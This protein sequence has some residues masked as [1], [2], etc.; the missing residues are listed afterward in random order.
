MNFSNILNISFTFV[1]PSCKCVTLHIITRYKL[2]RDFFK[3]KSIYLYFLIEHF[4]WD[5]V[6]F[7]QFFR[8]VLLQISFRIRNDVFRVP[9]QLNFGFDQIRIH[10]TDNI[11]IPQWVEKCGR[12]CNLMVNRKQDCFLYQTK[13]MFMDGWIFFARRSNANRFKNNGGVTAY[14]RILRAAILRPEKRKSLRVTTQL[15]SE[16]CEHGG[17][18]SQ[19]R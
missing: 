12:R 2:F 14:L 18:S 1:L 10:N 16:F 5:V 17:M 8:Q 13:T 11:P 7:Y 19:G 6:K 9:I 4:C 15:K 3:I